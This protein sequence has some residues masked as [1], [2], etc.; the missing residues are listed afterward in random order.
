[1]GEDGVNGA[2]RKVNSGA[3]HFEFPDTGKV[4]SL[5]LN[6]AMREFG[7]LAQECVQRAAAEGREATH[8]DY[9]DAVAAWVGE[10]TGVTIDADEADAINDELALAYAELK[11]KAAD[12]LSSL[13]RTQD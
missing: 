10:A 9:L 1:M 13:R 5:K 11:K 8:N 3:V 7:R 12:R 6:H 4:V 2:T